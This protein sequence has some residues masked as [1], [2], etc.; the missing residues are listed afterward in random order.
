[1]KHFRPEF[2]DK[3]VIYKFVTM[4]MFYSFLFLVSSL[5]LSLIVRQILV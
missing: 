5:I 4:Y 3:T 2:T 1:M